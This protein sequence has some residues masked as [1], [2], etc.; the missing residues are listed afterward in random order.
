MNPL[1]PVT[2]LSAG[3]FVGLVIVALA[4]GGGQLLFKLAAQRLIVGRGFGALLA[5]FVTPPMAASLVLY[6][7]ATVLWV[8]LLHGFPLSRAYPFVALAFALVPLMSWLVFGETLGIRYVVGLT[9]MLSG[10]YL[11][12][13]AS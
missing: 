10:L 2:S 11:I 4:L 5:S 7:G 1:L 3:R 6:A 12:A 8:Y 13:T 9:I